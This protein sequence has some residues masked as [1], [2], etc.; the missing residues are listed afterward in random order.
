MRRTE[1][2]M[3]L[4]EIMIAITI[5]LIL[6]TGILT[7]L[8]N[9]K[10]TYRAQD[11]ISGIQENGRFA[12]KL[13]TER[14][15]SAGFSGCST[16]ELGSI[17][18]TLNNANQ[19]P[20]NFAVAIEG[21]E[22]DNSGPG[23]TVTLTDSTPAV[24]STASDWDSNSSGTGTSL[25]ADLLDHPSLAGT[26][27]LPGDGVIPG[28]DVLIVRSAG[29][30]RVKIDRNN[31]VNNQVLFIDG[32]DVGVC[33]LGPPMI[34][35]I[36]TGDILLVSDC[37]K[38]RVFQAT[39]LTNTGGCT[40]TPCYE[41]AHSNAPFIPGN[42]TS[43]WGGPSAPKEELFGTDAEVLKMNTSSFYIGV[44]INN[45]PALFVK[46]NNLLPEELID[47]VE[48]MQV[49]YGEDTSVATPVV[50]SDKPNIATRYVKADDVGDWGRVVSARVSLLLRT[51][52]PVRSTN[53]NTVYHLTGGTDASATRVDP[54]NDK[55]FR[56]VYTTTINL[57]NKG[58]R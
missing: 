17:T 55:L 45:S 43:S 34:S 10:N 52:K 38:S 41:L 2:G 35:G 8:V 58:L 7:I 42:L 39:S 29:D 48:S 21:Y 46:K 57:R 31:D 33:P 51:D 23:A 53:D 54:V 26:G 24:G 37:Q 18:N 14:V 50:A 36:C 1:S 30:T 19:S 9:N 20:Y 5:G 25:P 16:D 44:G 22:A 40:S 49:L 11:A 15:R 32:T 3:T 28:T 4:V 12:M 47:N 56:R 6:L 27:I 13:I